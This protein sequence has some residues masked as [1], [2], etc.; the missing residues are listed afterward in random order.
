MASTHEE[1]RRLISEEAQET[2][3]PVSTLEG[4]AEIM[5]EFDE[6][7]DELKLIKKSIKEMWQLI[8][9]GEVTDAVSHTNFI[10][11]ET[12]K[13]M[14]GSIRLAS[15]SIAFRQAFTR[16]GGEGWHF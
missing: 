11:Q 1:I 9:E 6:T 5:K 14:A 3:M 8:K 2:D 16:G 10:E 7:E 12:E 4:W 15:K 13:M